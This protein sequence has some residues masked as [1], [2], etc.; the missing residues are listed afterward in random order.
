[1]KRE[2]LFEGIGKAYNLLDRRRENLARYMLN[3]NSPDSEERR[4]L[5]SFLAKHE[6]EVTKESLVAISRAYSLSDEEP[7]IELCKKLK[8]SESQVDH[9]SDSVYNW[10]KQ[11]RLECHKTFLEEVEKMNVLPEFYMELNWGW[12]QVQK[13]L[14][15]LH[16]KWLKKVVR[17][18]GRALLREYGSEEAVNKFLKEKNLIVEGY[19][20]EEKNRGSSAIILTPNGYELKSCITAFKKEVMLVVRKLHSL[21]TKLEG[22][23]DNTLGEKQNVLDFVQAFIDF[24]MEKDPHKQGERWSEVDRTRKL[25]TG[26]LFAPNC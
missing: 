21:H 19:G 4:Y 20:S 9:L 13:E 2:D 14:P 17:E 16:I 3:I 26:P 1:M 18:S 15:K 11:D 10:S 25:I 12:F 5:E 22:L 24:F 23:E 6:I 8:Y 7:L